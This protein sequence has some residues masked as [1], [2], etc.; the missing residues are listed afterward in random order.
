MTGQPV[1]LPFDSAQGD[2]FRSWQSFSHSVTIR[3]MPYHHCIILY[4]VAF[5]RILAVLVVSGDPA[6]HLVA[7]ELSCG[8][9]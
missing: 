3:L 7:K 2:F 8:V 5:K 9:A 1:S 4:Q 6:R